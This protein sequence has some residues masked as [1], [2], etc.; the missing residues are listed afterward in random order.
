MTTNS[1]VEAQKEIVRQF[2]LRNSAG[3]IPGV[4]SLFRG[5]AT[6]WLPTTRETLGMDKLP[7]AL[8]AVQSRLEG[9]IRYELGTMVAEPN[10]VSV[11]L[12]GFATT[13]EGATYNNLYNV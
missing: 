1:L 2:F 7:A 12:E 9:G 6:Y 4:M 11:Q 13:I 5:D 10:K 8:K 3:N